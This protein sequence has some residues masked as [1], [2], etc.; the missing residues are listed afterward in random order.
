MGA[1]CNTCLPGYDPNKKC[2]QCLPGYDIS[3]KCAKITTVCLNQY[4]LAG[5]AVG[6]MKGQ[7]VKVSNRDATALT[8]CRDMCNKA[9]NK[10]Q[11]EKT[12][13]RNLSMNAQGQ[14]LQSPTNATPS[15]ENIPCGHYN[16][17][18]WKKKGLVGRWCALYPKVHV[19]P[20]GHGIVAGWGGGIWPYN[21]KGTKGIPVTSCI[22]VP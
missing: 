7:T 19:A 14:W 11:A 9:G 18:D 8:Q 13:V 5:T 1:K 20:S 17:F 12:I 10:A 22:T 4:D 15:L 6:A 21:Q 16:I 3:N 2:T